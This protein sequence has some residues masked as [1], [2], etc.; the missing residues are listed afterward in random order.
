MRLLPVPGVFQPHSDSWLLADHIRQE[1]LRPGTTVLDLCAGSGVLAVTAARC[2]A[3]TVVAVD[4]SRRALLCTRINARLNGARIQTVRGDLFE[5]VGAQR[6]DLIVSNPPYLPGPGER[7]PRR[8]PARAWEGGIRGRAFLER[9]CARAADH[10][11]PGGVVLLVHS[12][13]CG[14]RETVE[15][16]CA[17]GL[18]AEVVCRRRGPLG[19]QLSR[20]RGFL[21][22]HGL[23]ED[24]DREELLIVRARLP[25][26]AQTTV[27]PVSGV[28]QRS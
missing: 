15:S 17:H 23:L 19:P 22:R 14:E 1:R 18:H 6:F 21:R 5:P 4:V 3:R 9:I 11:N 25:D 20:R 2:G 13:V 8:G 24:G 26:R 28:A 10:L 7:L 27:V 12:S 16:L